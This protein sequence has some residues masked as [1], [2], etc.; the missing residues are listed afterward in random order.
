MFVM[1][2]AALETDGL[3]LVKEVDKQSPVVSESNCNGYDPP[4]KAISTAKIFGYHIKKQ[5]FDASAYEEKFYQSILNEVCE[6]NLLLLEKNITRLKGRKI[7]YSRTSERQLCSFKAKSSWII[8]RPL[9]DLLKR[10]RK[11]GG[12]DD[13]E[14]EQ[15][16]NG[17]TVLI[18]RDPAWVINLAKRW[19][20]QSNPASIKV[21][22]ISKELLEMRLIKMDNLLEQ[23]Q[24]NYLKMKMKEEGENY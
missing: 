18:S 10:N 7:R 17:Q 15:E 16:I 23:I 24:T 5:Q 9:D 20:I 22:E 19:L 2:T 3:E 6:L 21:T 8:Q 11:R 4:D 12:L 14:E 1:T 13:I